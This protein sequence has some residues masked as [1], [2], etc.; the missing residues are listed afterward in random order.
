MAFLQYNEIVDELLRQGFVRTENTMASLPRIVTVDPTGTIGDIVRSVLNLVDRSVRLIDT[1]SGP[2]ALEEIALSKCAMVI[3]AWDLQNEMRGLELALRVKQ[4]SPET[5]VLILADVS[6]PEELDAETIAESPFLYMSRPVEIDQFARVLLAGLSGE[7]IRAA[8]K[9]P[10]SKPS[11]TVDL[12]PVPQFE[13]EAA[14]VIVDQL[15]TDLGA[16]AIILSSRAGEVIMERGAVGYL[17]REQLTNALLPTVTT[18]VQVKDMV[19]GQS[20]SLLFY[21]GD[22]YDL[23]VLSVGL[24]HFVCIAFDGEGGQRQ[25]GAVSRYG[26]RAAEDLIALLGAE[27]WLVQRVI[28]EEEEAAPRPRKKAKAEPAAEEPVQLERAEMDTTPTHEPEPAPVAEPIEDL[29]IDILFNTLI[30]DK[31]M[32]DLFDPDKLEEM[33]KEDLQKG[34]IDFE[35]AKELGILKD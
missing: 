25:F 32:V 30:D 34:Q 28:V 31:N 24:H 19:G 12:G 4:A 10:A 27:A 5:A 33:A 17:D 26:R 6:D 35:S 2:Q 13:V 18:N 29:D 16:M 8:I 21:D 22:N 14:Q 20:S 11:V 23:F 3:T 9:A 7:D 1:P 15:L